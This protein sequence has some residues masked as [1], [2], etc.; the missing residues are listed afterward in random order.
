MKFTDGFWQLR[1]GVH[2]SY[3]TEVRDVRLDDDR[4]A[5]YAAV[6]RVRRRGDTLNAPLITV[7]AHAPAEG[8]IA[9]RLT[10]HAGKR[11]RGPDFALP[12]AAAPAAD[13]PGAGSAATTR[14]EGTTAELT[15]GP[16]TLRL[17][18]EGA[19]GLEFLDQDGRLLTAAGPK[20]SAFATL[21]DG[22]HHMVAQLALG[23]PGPVQRRGP[24]VGV[25]RGRRADAQGRPRPLHGPHRSPGPPA[26]L[27]VRPLAE[28]VLHHLLRRG[29]RHLVRR[30]HG[31][32]R[33]PAQRV[34]LRL[35]LDARVPVVRLRV[36]PGRLPRPGG[37]DRP[38]QGQGSEDLRLDQPVHRAEGRPVRRGG[39]RGLL[40]QDR[41]RR[42]LAVGQ[43]AGRHGAGRLHEPRGH[44]LV[45]GQAQGA[46]RP[47]RR[48]LQ[49]RLRRARPHRRGLARRLRP[50]A[51][52]QLLHA[53][54]QQGRLR[55]PGG[56]ARRR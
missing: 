53:P 49:D 36:G 11:R 43:V 33:H 55:T 48:R 34:P 1:S 39:P 40:R 42:H 14:T 54:V 46:P 35:L 17:P 47:G 22:S 12:G 28:H 25:L 45:P 37:H 44:G 50:G 2:A 7:E 16:L 26:G 21:D 13:G 10:H 27:V 23:V 30:R 32:T 41:R 6:K 8:V 31:R 52:A 51:H 20:G 56:G 18:T 38:A 29:H 19:F 5:A 15:S 4:L 24:V 9:V 3:A